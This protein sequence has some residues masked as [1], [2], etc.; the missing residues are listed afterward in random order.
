M[1]A[2]VP[3]DSERVGTF[4][5]DDAREGEPPRDDS[6][7]TLPIK[8]LPGAYFK[9][10]RGD[11]SNSSLGF[12]DKDQQPLPIPEG[13]ELRTG[14]GAPATRCGDAYPVHPLPRRVQAVTF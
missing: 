12:V 6:I 5:H 2:K 4:K 7:E 1:A 10:Q 13:M 9:F 14:R 3:E 11:E 8:N